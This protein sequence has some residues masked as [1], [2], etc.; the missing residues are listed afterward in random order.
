[1]ATL[2]K[3]TGDRITIVGNGPNRTLTLEQMQAAV[4]GYIEFAP[5]Y[6]RDVVVCN[7]EGLLKEL[8]PNPV[9]SKTAGRTLVG[10]VLFCSDCEIE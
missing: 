4:G 3:T 2:V 8:P 10:D 7:E 1:M 6:G 9:A 5:T